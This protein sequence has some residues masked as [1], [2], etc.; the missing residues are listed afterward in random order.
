MNDLFKH[1]LRNRGKLTSFVISVRCADTI[2]L[3][4]LLT[5]GT[6]SS[7]SQQRFAD[8]TWSYHARWSHLRATLGES[9]PKT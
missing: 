5:A 6:C 1:P 7:C 2:R 8:E 3:F 9:C 4:S